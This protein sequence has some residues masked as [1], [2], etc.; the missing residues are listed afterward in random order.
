MND[1]NI[2]IGVIFLLKY[3]SNRSYFFTFCDF[4]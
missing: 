2:Y 4:R 1:P 3:Q